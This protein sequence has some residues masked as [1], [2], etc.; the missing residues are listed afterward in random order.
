M[1]GR[2]FIWANSMPNP[3][4]EKLDRILVS[5]EW[6]QKFPLAKVM[7]LSRDISDHTP[8]LLDNG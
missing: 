4:F 5:T 7:A 2:R 1:S 3:T 6:E 8:L